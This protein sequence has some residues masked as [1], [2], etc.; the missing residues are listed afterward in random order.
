LIQLD[1]LVSFFQLIII[2]ESIQTMAISFGNDI[3]E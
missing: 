3:L 1:N 2:L